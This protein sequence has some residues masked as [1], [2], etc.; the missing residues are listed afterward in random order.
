MKK[1]FLAIL[2]SLVMLFALLPVSAF[3]ADVSA[4]NLTLAEA[5]IG[6][7]LPQAAAEENANYEV[8]TSWKKG[9]A[10]VD[11]DANA[12]VGEYTATITVTPKSEY[13][14][15]ATTAFKLNSKAVENVTAGE[16]GAYSFTY[17]VTLTAEP[18]Q[19]EEVAVTLAEPVE[20]EEMPVADAAKEAGYTVAT[21]WEKKT[22]QTREAAGAAGTVYTATITATCKAG[23]VFAETVTGKI[24]TEAVTVTKS[25][26]GT[27]VIMTKDFTVAIKPTLA[28][29]VGSATDSAITFKADQRSYVVNAATG[30]TKVT[31]TTNATAA[32]MNGNTEVTN[33]DGSAEITLGAAGTV[34]TITVT[35][36]STEYTVKVARAAADS[37]GNTEIADKATV[38]GSA[39]SAEVNED[40]ALVA[41][42]NAGENK[43]VAIDTTASSGGDSVT[44]A[45]VTLPAAV[46]QSLSE[47]EVAAEVKT[48]VGTV[49]LPAA[50]VT[51]ALGD[52]ASA[53][54]K[55]VVEDKSDAPATT[56]AA[57]TFEVSIKDESDQEVS[58]TGLA[59]GSEITLAF[60]LPQDIDVTTPV[61]VHVKNASATTAA[62]KYERLTSEVKN[63]MIIGKTSHL[64]TFAIVSEEALTDSPA[65]APKLRY[66]HISDLTDKTEYFGGTL[67]IKNDSG[68]AQKYLVAIGDP[69]LKV[70]TKNLSITY[71]VSL[72][73]GGKYT[74]PCQNVFKVAVYSLPE[75][76]DLSQGFN[77]DVLID[78][79]NVTACNDAI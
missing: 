75:N 3:A 23:F 50:A 78:W 55:L 53:V 61:L 30:E 41:I 28:V 67:E 63:G 20:T 7:K 11:V 19:I 51:K 71:V 37:T 36:G 10:A 66:T 42:S 12:E 22:E 56:E 76:Q 18:K 24:N 68:S 38:S 59:K 54:L 43:T 46:T 77:A 1:R 34:T 62:E 5:A 49:T 44:S 65:V 48:D 17:S 40:N 4:V 8:A 16:G 70:G 21:T 35:I 58:V 47:N 45:V 31:V 15:T 64:S 2:L 39:A 57:A 13:A 79:K 29:K 6:S 72:A 73:A 32:I 60:P 9:D 27:A 26:D 25:A 52:E 74:L 14:L 33:D 69:A